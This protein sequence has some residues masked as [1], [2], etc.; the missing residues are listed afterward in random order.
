MISKILSFAIIFVLVGDVI[1]GGDDRDMG[2]IEPIFN[3]IVVKS[4]YNLDTMTLIETSS[5]VEQTVADSSVILVVHEACKNKL[6]L[7]NVNIK[8]FEQAL[9]SDI[10]YNTG[11]IDEMGTLFSPERWED[12]FIC[13]EN[14]QN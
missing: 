13:V 4:E 2:L 8:R 5:V 11:P 10:L 1:A 6:N 3:K 9:A 12:Y 14:H 7:L